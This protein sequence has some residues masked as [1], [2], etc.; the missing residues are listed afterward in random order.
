MGS[1]KPWAHGFVANILL[2]VAGELGDLLVQD[3]DYLNNTPQEGHPAHGDL[4]FRTAFA[5]TG[6]EVASLLHAWVSRPDVPQTHL[7]HPLPHLQALPG[8][9]GEDGDRD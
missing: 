8:L 4:P 2:V 3:A 6:L 9:G 7:L 5:R 1:Y